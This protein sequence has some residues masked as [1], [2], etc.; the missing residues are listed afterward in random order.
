MSELEVL[1]RVERLARDVKMNTNSVL[2]Y[3]A[4]K[5]VHCGQPSSS[6][7]GL[8]NE[9]RDM[10]TKNLRELEAAFIELDLVRAGARP[11]S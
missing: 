1:R 11:S 7:R 4:A 8:Y 6:P 2:S 9:V 10:L 3:R 5:C